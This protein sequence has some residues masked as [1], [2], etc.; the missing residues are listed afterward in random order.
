[1]NCFENKIDSFLSCDLMM[2][3][4]SQPPMYN[5][6]ASTTVYGGQAP[7]VAYTAQPGLQQHTVVVPS[8][9]NVSQTRFLWVD[10]IKLI[11]SISPNWQCEDVCRKTIENQHHVEIHDVTGRER[12]IRSHSSARFCFEL[13]GNSN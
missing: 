9:A 3:E 13:S 12:L 2:D 10:N 1:M 4:K 7:S 5:P 8:A 11:V 6:P